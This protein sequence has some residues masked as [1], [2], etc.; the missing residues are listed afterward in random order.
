M[1]SKIYGLIVFLPQINVGVKRSFQKSIQK[2][3]AL[4]KGFKSPFTHLQVK[5]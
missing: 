3:K 4:L 1:F 2:L 5:N